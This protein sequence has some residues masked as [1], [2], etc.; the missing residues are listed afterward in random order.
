M[1]DEEILEAYRA[2]KWAN[3][4]RWQ[5]ATFAQAQPH[6]SLNPKPGAHGA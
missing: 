1:G 4:A 3:N 6:R 2:Q 5:L